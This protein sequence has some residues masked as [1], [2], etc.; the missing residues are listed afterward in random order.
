MGWCDPEL[1]DVDRIG[2]YLGPVADGLLTMHEVDR[3]VGN[4]RANND[5]QLIEPV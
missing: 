4:A 5:P 3:R 1:T 2:A